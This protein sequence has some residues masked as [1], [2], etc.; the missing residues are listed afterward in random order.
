MVSLDSIKM[1]L[2]LVRSD[3]YAIWMKVG[4]ALKSELGDEGFQLWNE[5]SSQHTEKYKGSEVTK[6]VWD[7][8][9]A[10][11]ITIATLFILAN[12]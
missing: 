6:T 4:C 3:D 1:A 11:K 8:L 7:S 9:R 5:W 10:N 2:C 12:I